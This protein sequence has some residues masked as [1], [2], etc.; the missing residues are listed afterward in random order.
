MALS[1]ALYAGVSGL[2]A[3]G[4]ALSII[5]NDVANSNTVGFK[6]SIASFSDI[7]SSSLAGGS[8]VGRGA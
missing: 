4:T 6:G 2:N 7:L 3:D 1:T 5:G 8:Q